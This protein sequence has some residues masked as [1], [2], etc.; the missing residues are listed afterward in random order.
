[1]SSEGPA[2]AWQLYPGRGDA[3]QG[4]VTQ[5]PAQTSKNHGNARR[6]VLQGPH[7]EQ[8]RIRGHKFPV[9]SLRHDCRQ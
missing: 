3:T 6:E 7:P 1:M 4:E 5:W 2:Q 9:G 8:E